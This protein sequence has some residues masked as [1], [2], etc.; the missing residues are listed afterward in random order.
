VWSG[1]ANSLRL[2]KKKHTSTQSSTSYAFSIRYKAQPKVNSRVVLGDKSF[3]AGSVEM[4]GRKI[5]AVHQGYVVIFILFQK[6][7]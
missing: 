5:Y 3:E 4:H 2:V 1:N 7:Y 6:S